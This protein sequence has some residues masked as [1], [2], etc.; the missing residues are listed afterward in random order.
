MPKQQSLPT[1]ALRRRSLLT[2]ALGSALPLAHA[3]GPA[4]K[5]DAAGF[6]RAPQMLGAVLA[7]NGR[8]LAM[9]TVG[10]HGRVM[11]TVLQLD[12]LAPKVV[13]G[14]DNADVERVVWVNNDRLAFDLSDRET[15]QGKIDA[16]PG[17]FAV[18]HDG[19]LLRQLV[20]RQVAWLKD[21]NDSRQLQPWNTFLL[22]GSTQRQGDAVLAVRPEAYSDKDAGF[23]KLLRLDTRSGRA[24]TMDSPLHSVGWWPDAQGNL[25]VAL[26]RDGEKAALRWKDP[27]T[28]QW[29]A[30][31]E[32]NAYTED[33]DLQVRHVGADGKLYV[34]AR[35]GR[36]KQ[37]MWLLD[38]ATGAWSAKPL[39]ESPLFDVDA[40]VLARQDKVLGLRFT[41]DAEVT[42]WL[43]ADMQTLQAQIDK[44]LPRTVN[45]LS[46]PWSGDAP[47]VLIEAF[48]DIQPTQY[49]LFNRE[50]RKFTR[51]GGERPDIEAKQMAAMDMVRIK[52]RDG[53]EIPVWLSLP[54]GAE[55]LEKKKLPMV[56]LVHGGPFVRA[57]GWTWDAEVQ[58]LN[59]RGYAVLQP[60]FRGTLGF[61]AS[62]ARAGWR[63]WGKAMQSD[64][65][66][67]TRW[68]IDQGIADPKRIAIAGASYGG[69]AALM[70]LVRDADLFRC[71]VAWVG[72]TDLDMLH[73]VNWSDMS[74]SFKTHGMPALIGDRVKDAAD[75]KDNSPL[76]HAAK[77][78][79]PLLLAYGSADRRV[80]LIHGEAF[81]KAV[82]AGNAALE[83]VVYQDEGHGWRVPA[84]RIDFWNRTAAF[85][86]KHLAPR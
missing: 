29:R 32:F 44:V 28:D 49:L 84:N 25:R 70:G 56:V 58:F 73:T 53:L 12:T 24:E 72:V 47:W 42:Q 13:Y 26:T 48:A 8:R 31:T 18:D 4:G 83:W 69:Y 67:A 55:K 39:A 66:D 62:H 50:T 86:D 27:A 78:R 54:P 10:P 20:E 36:D 19:G 60:Q 5:P 41:I 30:L 38:P 51:L 15:P 75:L 46:L 61:G 7:P 77:I 23:F 2:L 16:G 11:L 82:Q 52:A 33:G 34:S 79:Q 81:R 45:R 14:S 65:A 9:R 17:L 21:G 85:L 74:D 40:Q 64:V 37:A 43:D 76:T 35:H 59:A 71:A 57:P 63:Q 68:A 80:P 3:Q 22:N 1:T 6:F